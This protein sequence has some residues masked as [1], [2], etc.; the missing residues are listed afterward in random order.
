MN[1][2]KPLGAEQ[3]MKQHDSKT[4]DLLIE[5]IAIAFN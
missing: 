4:A 5:D 3:F 1:E 2:I